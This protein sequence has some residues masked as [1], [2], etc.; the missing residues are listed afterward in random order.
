MPK[1]Q[2][3]SQTHSQYLSQSPFESGPSVVGSA[4]SCDLLSLLLEL[5]ILL[6]LGGS[7]DAGHVRDSILILISALDE[8]VDC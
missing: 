7:G 2:S 1:S 3:Q 6:A 8:F 5:I 4:Q